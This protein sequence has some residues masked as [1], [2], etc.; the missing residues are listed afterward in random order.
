MYHVGDAEPSAAVLVR[1]ILQETELLMKF[2]TVCH[3]TSHH[4][5]GMSVD[6][7]GDRVHNDVGPLSEWILK[8]THKWI[9]LQ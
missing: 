4:Y 3:N 7:F 1:T 9:K 2:R 5:I 6:I 8:V